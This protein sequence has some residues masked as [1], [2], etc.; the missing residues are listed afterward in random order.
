MD[1]TTAAAVRSGDHSPHDSPRRSILRG[2]IARSSLLVALVVL[3]VDQLAKQWA[4]DA[5]ADGSE[6]HVIWTLQW[7]L[8]YN[9]GMAFSRGR[10]LGPVIALVA[11]LVVIVLVVSTARTESRVARFAAGLLIGGALG[12]LADRVFR[13]DGWLKGG[14]V[15]FI[16]FQWWPIFNVA[17]I[18]V[19]VGA[20]LFALSALIGPRPLPSGSERS[21]D[22]GA[23]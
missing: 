8:A 5:L 11:L 13:G 1:D 15:D 2:R 20:V 6:R 21:V 7:N 4:V 3:V 12:N 17:D 23:S 19:S 9:T 18:G 14:V 22:G 10:G 16:D